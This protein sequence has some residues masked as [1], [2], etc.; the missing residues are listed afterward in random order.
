VFNYLIG[1]N[2]ISTDGILTEITHQGYDVKIVL[3]NSVSGEAKII[4]SIFS[5]LS[6]CLH[7][8][9]KSSKNLLELSSSTER[10]IDA[11]MKTIEKTL[12][13]LSLEDPLLGIKISLLNF[14]KFFFL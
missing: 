11:C 5:C 6:F 3:S 8:L 13:T 9:V 12:K 7:E 10:L 4:G 2:K 1:S 14:V